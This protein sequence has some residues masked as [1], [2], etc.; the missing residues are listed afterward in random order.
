MLI[1]G[2][3]VLLLFT[4]IIL[5]YAHQQKKKKTIKASDT[6][7]VIVQEAEEVNA[8]ET[9]VSINRLPILNSQQQ[10]IGYNLSDKGRPFQSQ[11]LP[12]LILF[13]G[14][15]VY[16]RPDKMLV[17]QL[18]NDTLEDENLSLL[19]AASIL[20]FPHLQK[21]KQTQQDKLQALTQAGFRI[22]TTPSADQDLLSAIQ[23]IVIDAHMGEESIR[24]ELGLVRG[25]KLRVLA[26]HVNQPDV[27]RFLRSLGINL[28][29]GFF[30]AEP[31]VLQVST[32][33]SQ[34][35]NILSLIRMVSLREEPD[36]IESQFKRDPDLTFRMLKYMNS[37]ALSLTHKITS[38][39]VAIVMMGYN[40]L[41]RWLSVL[42]AA[43]EAV[44]AESRQA[45]Y[46]TGSTRGRCME[47]LADK[48]GLNKDAQDEAF[49]VGM[50]SLIPVM[51]E[52]PVE[53][54][55]TDLNLPD[56]V[57]TT[58]VKNNGPYSSLFHLVCACE[59]AESEKVTELCQHLQLDEDMVYQTHIEAGQWAGEL[60]A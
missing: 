51:L 58:L 52:Q 28:Y 24:H 26:I 36:T 18:E 2:L 54:L 13:L 37:A 55:L 12:A 47:L 59:R 50:F 25:K 32:P 43:C 29:Q 11:T 22:A 14:N 27:Y 15:E 38:I 4:A 60:E 33:N 30:F 40:N 34:V 41:L 17:I 42:L 16:Q 9:R 57:L 10:I 39:K 56:G 19:P 5:I 21:P 48:S 23:F 8:P 46:E 31:E 1:V 45:L 49:M 6:A 20:Y 3:V 53:T 35:N 44:P 7:T